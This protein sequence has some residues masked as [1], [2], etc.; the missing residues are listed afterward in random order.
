MVLALLTLLAHVLMSPVADTQSPNPITGG[1]IA[2]RIVTASGE[3][4]PGMILSA[5]MQNSDATGRLMART[6]AMTQTNELGAFRLGA[7]GEGTYVVIA[8]PPPPPPFGQPPRPSGAPVLLP[9]YY[10]GTASADAAQIITIASGQTVDGLQFS[11][12][13]TPGYNV[14]GVV[15]DEAGS[16]LS[17]VPVTLMIDAGNGGISAPSTGRSDE[18]G[19]FHIGGVVPGSYRLFA[20]TPMMSTTREGSITVVSGL[21]GGGVAATGGVF[22]GGRGIGAPGIGGPGVPPPTGMP[23]T[24]QT[25]TMISTPI[26]VIVGNDDVASLKLVVTTRK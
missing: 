6:V 2:G 9:T 3:P 17:N 20:G 19:T 15:L 12:A 24:A 14:S 1:A 18:Q 21:V 10:P 13:S 8:V 4:V 23:A 16:P 25:W 7:L 5:L 11:M 22:V 26:D